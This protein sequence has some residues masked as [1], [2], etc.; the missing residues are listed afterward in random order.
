MDG[1]SRLSSLE[2]QYVHYQC[3]MC[4]SPKLTKKYFITPVKAI[5]NADV[6]I[7]LLSQRSGYAAQIK[8]WLGGIMYGEEEN[9]WAYIIDESS[10]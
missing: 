9:D 2:L 10:E 8:T 7:D 4:K 3:T 6:D 1:L 5:R